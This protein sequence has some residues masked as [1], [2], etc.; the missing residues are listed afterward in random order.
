VIGRGAG[1]KL[2]NQKKRKKGDGLRGP[3]LSKMFIQRRGNQKGGGKEGG[4]RPLVKT[5]EGQM[6]GDPEKQQRRKLKDM[7]AKQQKK[8]R[9]EKKKKRMLRLPEKVET[10]EGRKDL[11]GI[12]SC[13]S[14]P[15]HVVKKGRIAESTFSDKR[16]PRNIRWPLKI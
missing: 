11:P 15:I 1:G 3:R 9:F 16:P 10:E 8:K 4:K 12:S 7:R 13:H 2:R 6:G 14:P 5:K